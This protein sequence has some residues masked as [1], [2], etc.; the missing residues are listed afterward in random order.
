MLRYCLL[1]YLSMANLQNDSHATLLFTYNKM[2]SGK[3][4]TIL[5]KSI[6]NF[7]QLNIHNKNTHKGKVNYYK[8]T[9]VMSTL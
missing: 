2:A 5:P 8:I 6:R 7:L 9:N 1:L 3:F 4:S